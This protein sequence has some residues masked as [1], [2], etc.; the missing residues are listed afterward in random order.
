MADTKSKL[1]PITVTLHWIV[2][3]TIIG[4]LAVGI[5]MD[6]FEVRSLYPLHKSVG[7]IIFVVILLR[8]MWRIKNGWPQPVREY[9]KWEQALSK[10]VHY[11]LLL[12][13]V[14]IPI[15]GMMMSGG[16]GHGINVFGLE[17]LASNPDP[18]NPGKVLPL[19]ASIGSLGHELHGLVAY[20]LIGALVLHVSGALKHHVMDG[21][22]TLRRMLGAKV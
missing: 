11:V 20:V 16:G 9:Q 13:S 4:L 12:G 14:I 7:V 3:L 21:D 8:V 1:S 18:A 19:N 5:I 2:A 6:E 10:V 17:L 15:T 22:G